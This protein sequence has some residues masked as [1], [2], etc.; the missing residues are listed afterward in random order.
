MHAMH[1]KGTE[2]TP[3][4]VIE[5]KPLIESPEC[6]LHREDNVHCFAVGYNHALYQTHFNGTKWTHYRQLRDDVLESPSC[7]AFS[8]SKILC[9]TRNTRGYIIR[10]IVD[11]KKGMPF[12]DDEDRK[13]R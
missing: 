6:I 10:I 3:F 9:F 5:E 13:R 8:R 11:L 12:A 2:Y 4:E 7:V 1:D